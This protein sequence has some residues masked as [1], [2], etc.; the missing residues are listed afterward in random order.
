MNGSWP[1]QNVGEP[2]YSWP[3]NSTRKDFQA[4][5]NLACFNE[6]REGK[7]SLREQDGDDNEESGEGSKSNS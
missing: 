2:E 1:G 6:L 4:A 7:Y 3:S 5:K